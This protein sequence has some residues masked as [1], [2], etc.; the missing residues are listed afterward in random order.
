LP[1]CVEHWQAYL[2]ASK[3]G[4]WFL[5]NHV[6]FGPA[7]TK[8][9]LEHIDPTIAIIVA[10]WH[11]RDLAGWYK[12][13][14]KDHPRLKKIYVIGPDVPEG[15]VSVDELLNPKIMEKYEPQD[16]DALKVGVYEPWLIMETSGTT[17]LPKLVVH[18]SYYFQT[19]FG[20][21][22]ERAGFRNYDRCLLLGPL[23]GTTGKAYGIGMPLHAATTI[24][25]LT[26][27]SDEAIC[28]I[29][30]EEGIT[31]WGGIPTLGERSIF[32]EI[33]QKYDLSSMKLFASAGAPISQEISSKLMDR[34]VKIINGYGTTEAGAA[35]LLSI[36]STREEVLGTVGQ[37]P[38]GHGVALVDSEG[39]EVQEGEVGEVYIWNIHH[40]YYN[41]P[42]YQAEAWVQDGK[43]KGWNRTG[44][45]GR[46]DKKGNLSIVGRSKDMI[47]RGALN[48]FPKE[49]E[50]ILSSHPR[51][52]EIAIVKMPDPILREKACAFVTLKKGEQLT[53]SEV[54][55]FLESKGLA[56]MKYPER[57]EV[58]EAMPM[59][60]G[61]KIN[62]LDLEKSIAQKVQDETK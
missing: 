17:G 3:I 49:I 4:C 61:G 21:M 48:I 33:A 62:K 2:A 30:E 54:N 59:G 57:L 60:V 51:I 39:N 26:E 27:Y 12:E 14:Q 28:R 31:V 44:D 46:F 1:N 19:F 41:Q 23:S 38:E 18:G 56:K 32:G 35:G 6:D 7:E 55:A 8:A 52:R 53:L 34:G 58:I 42:E 22:T 16:L 37:R 47:L 40:G 10:D 13:Y 5:S 20:C 11:G 29:T 9:I 25:Y 45:L 43:W 24:V 50:D 15:T 36:T